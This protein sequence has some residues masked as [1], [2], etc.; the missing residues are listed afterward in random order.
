[1]LTTLSDG[2]GSFTGRRMMISSGVMRPFS[3]TL[4]REFRSPQGA[5]L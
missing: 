5:S 2:N 4:S 3:A 1:M